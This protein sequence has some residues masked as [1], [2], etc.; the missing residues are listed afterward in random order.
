MVILWQPVAQAGAPQGHGQDAT[1][2]YR[3]DYEER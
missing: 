3:T 1:L 2:S